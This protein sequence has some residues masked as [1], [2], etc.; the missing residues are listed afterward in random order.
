LSMLGSRHGF[1]RV[2][3]PQ[4]VKT[5]SK[6]LRIVPSAP[7]SHLLR[8]NQLATS[9]VFV[10]EARF[11]SPQPIEPMPHA[12]TPPHVLLWQFD[13]IPCLACKVPRNSHDKTSFS[14]ACAAPMRSARSPKDC[15][16]TS[17]FPPEDK[18]PMQENR[19]RLATPSAKAL[20]WSAIHSFVCL[21]EGEVPRR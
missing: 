3:S 21:A 2:Y 18:Q 19:K 15:G 7:P 17:Q 5:T 20:L 13:D 11:E 8:Y 16:P 4:S 1:A 9:V 12:P 6:V 14:P 10:S